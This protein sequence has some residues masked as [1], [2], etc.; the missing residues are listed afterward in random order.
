MKQLC[1]LLFS[2]LLFTSCLNHNDDS[3][4]VNKKI[5]VAEVNNTL[6]NFQAN[7]DD[8]F[9]FFDIRV[10]SNDERTLFFFKK[11]KVEPVRW[12][13]VDDLELQDSRFIKLA[14]IS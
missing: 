1:H 9:S 11:N 6:N 14:N 10:D 12:I 4:L 3:Y 13:S 2:I 7:I 8:I 5:D